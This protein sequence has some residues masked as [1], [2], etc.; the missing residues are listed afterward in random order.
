MRRWFWRAFILYAL[1]PLI[2]VE[3][4][5]IGAYLLSNAA[6]RN[7]QL[8]NLEERAQQ[9]LAG[10]IQR[11]AEIVGWDLQS[12]EK[13]TR[14]FRGA[15]VQALQEQGFQPDEVER[16]RHVLGPKGLFYSRSDDGRAA[17]FYAKTTPLE[18]QDHAKALR[19]SQLDPL[20]RS[21]EEAG[22]LVVS[23]YFRSWDNYTR[24]YPFFDVL[25]KD[26]GDMPSSG[27][28]FYSRADERH[29]PEREPVWTDPY[30][31]PA[32]R[33]RM[34]TIAPVYH[35]DFLEGVV[36][37]EIDLEHLLAEI[38]TLGVPWQ[39]RAMLI[40]EG[41]NVMVLPEKGKTL[42]NSSV[43][44]PQHRR[45]MAHLLSSAG[46]EG[47]VQTAMLDGH[48][49]LLAW[50][51]I[52][53]TGW[54]LLLIVDK[55]RI[56]QPTRVL[57]AH[58]QKIGYLL[59]VG[60][61]LFHVLFLALWWLR[62][63]RLS[64][65]LEQP[66]SSIADMLRHLGKGLRHEGADRQSPLQVSR[67][68][69]LNV[70]ADAVRSSD[71]QLQA[72]EA[73]RSKAQ[74]LLE[75]VME[76]TTESLWEIMLEKSQIRVSSRFARRFALDAECVTFDEFNRLVHP[77][78]LERLRRRR[79]RFFSGADGVYE[80]EFRCVDRTGQYVWLLSRGQALERDVSGRVLYSAGTHVDISRLKAV[81]EDLRRATLEAQD[82]SRAKSRFLSSMSHELRT[83]L[84]AVQGFA[85][86]IELEVEGRPEANP[87]GEYA[88]EIVKA[89]RHLTALVGDII[90]LS[91]LEGRRQQ[92][93]I[94]PVEVGAM[95]ASCA[96]L[97]QPQIRE[98]QLHLQLMSV[99]LPLYVQ[100]DVCR[101]RQVLLNLLSN[102][103]KY[104]RPQGQV[105]LGH[106]VRS[107]C[108]RLWVK[109]T[110][111]GLD[112]E[113]QS[114]LFQPFQRLGRESSN[115]PGSGIGLVLCH[116]L[117][118][119]MNGSMGFHSKPGHGCRFWI[120]LPGAAAPME[121][122]ASPGEEPPAGQAARVGDDS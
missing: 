15:V 26:P 110:G 44:A 88:G 58:Y 69:E 37:L 45:E 3:S 17:S 18:R 21:I 60:L 1:I 61:L 65:E 79:E 52:P 103:I 40:D 76:S 19:L 48:E 113:Q 10:A 49:H 11:E 50:K 43:N 46:P 22:P 91:T 63:R 38:G 118:G 84:N 7:A 14:I 2:V 29:N 85:Q 111:P 59:I 57:A 80:V 87:V 104:N 54:R 8:G 20:M 100:A 42:G 27:Y 31:D 56:L 122:R 82:A 64:R 96:E 9:S 102:A 6:M 106:E 36:G 99:R 75:V 90:D 47:E 95:L 62:S 114:Q 117:A 25:Q 119:L 55:D 121:E 12:I 35:G 68:E 108:V 5:L 81:Q 107:D 98:S 28:N 92:L 97:V 41:G 53:Q 83:P 77:D 32:G 13:Q 51:G 72:S 115:I 74:R 67:I 89:G 94:R 4:V 34:A 120:D 105:T 24:S 101:L 93:H 116:E 23:V 70:M 66:I 16:A 30:L 86:L 112:V 73:E 109:D 78:D 39:G 71:R 33:W